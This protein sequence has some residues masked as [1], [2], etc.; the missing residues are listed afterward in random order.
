MRIGVPGTGMVGHAIAS[1]LVALGHEAMLV[2]EAGHADIQHQR[3]SIAHADGSRN[4]RSATT[5]VA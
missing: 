4:C 3:D 5:P 1:K 2:V